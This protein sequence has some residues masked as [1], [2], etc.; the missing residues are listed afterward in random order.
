MTAPLT[1]TPE[2]VLPGFPGGKLENIRRYLPDILNAL[3][4]ARL[5]SPRIVAYT[6]ATIAAETAGFIPI[7]EQPS[8]WNTAARPFDRYDGRKDLG[9]DHPGDGARYRGR[10]YVQLTGRYNYQKYGERIGVDLAA[11]PERAND[12][13]IAAQLLALFV[14]DREPRILEHLVRGRLAEARKAVN[15][16]THGMSRFEPAYRYFLSLFAGSD[17]R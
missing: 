3:W 1:L 12:A 16:G 8:K 13:K 7:A 11:D 15:G 14:A 5:D 9:N 2:R 6:L 4:E 17:E 10:G